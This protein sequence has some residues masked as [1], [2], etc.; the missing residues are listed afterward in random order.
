MQVVGRARDVLGRLLGRA[1]R[2]QR[3]PACL[4]PDARGRVENDPVAVRYDV[5]Q[6]GLC[7]REILRE[8][9]AG[10][11]GQRAGFPDQRHRARGRGVGQPDVHGGPPRVAC[12]AS[13]DVLKRRHGLAQQALRRLQLA[14]RGGYGLLR[15]LCRDRCRVARRVVGDEVGRNLRERVVHL[16][17]ERVDLA[18][19]RFVR[20]PAGSQRVLGLGRPSGGLQP[21]GGR[22]GRGERGVD[23]PGAGG[24][25]SGYLLDRSY[26]GGDVGAA[27]HLAE[28]LDVGGL[29]REQCVESGYL[30][31]ELF[32]SRPLSLGGGRAD[33]AR[34]RCLAEPREVIGESAGVRCDLLVVLGVL[35]DRRDP[36]GVRRM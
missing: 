15:P 31:G 18:R 9:A 26:I 7:R 36:V 5:L 33:V 16:P 17:R 6:V 20:R 8:Q 28:S 3:D 13:A 21:G 35:V 1:Q 27:G 29:L 30:P 19:S 11:A 10:L 4:E 14:A 22:A 24:D 25:E 23:L 2:G 34:G 32:A 12:Q